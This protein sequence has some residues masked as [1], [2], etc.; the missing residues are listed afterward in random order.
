MAC[1]SGFVQLRA[2]CNPIIVT[3][4]GCNDELSLILGEVYVDAN[5]VCW[6]AEAYDGFCDTTSYVVPFPLTLYA[7]SP[8]N[9]T[10][11]LVDNPATCPQISVNNTYDLC[12][13]WQNTGTNILYRVNTVN[14]TPINNLFLTRIFGDGYTTTGCTGGVTATS[15]WTGNLNVSLGPTSQLATTSSGWDF[16]E[17]SATLYNIDFSGDTYGQTF[18]NVS[19]GSQFI[20]CGLSSKELVNVY[21]AQCAASNDTPCPDP[22]PTPTQTLTSTLTPTVTETSTNTPTPTPTLTET[23][24]NTPTTTPTVTETSTNTPTPTPTL[25][26]TPTSTPTPTPTLTETPTSTPTLTPTPTTTSAAITVVQFQ[27]CETGTNIFRFGGNISPLTL[28]SVY[29]ITGSSDFLGC[30]TVVTDNNGGPLY[31][32]NGVTFTSTLGCAD[33]MCPATPKVGAVLNKCSDGTI[34][35]ALVDENVSFVGATYVYNGFC[36]SFIERGG[37]G[38]PDLGAPQ[39]SSCA[40]CVPSLTLTPTPTMPT[41]T[42]TPTEVACFC[43]DTVFCLDTTWSGLDGYTGTYTQSNGWYNCCHFYEGGTYNFGVIYYTGQFWCLSSSLGGPCLL[44]G[45]KTC[46]TGCP[47]FDSN[48][49]TVG[50]CPPPPIPPADCSVLDFYAYFDCNYTPPPT[51]VPCDIVDFTISAMTLTPTPTPTTQPCLNLGINF[52]MSSYT[53]S[54]NVTPTPTP[55]LTATNPIIISGNA[56]FEV[57]Q[58]QFSCVSVKVLIDCSTGDEYY[59]SDTLIYNGTTPIT[60]GMTIYANINGMFRCV[61][62]DRDDNNISSNS[63]ISIIYN[64]WGGGCAQCLLTPTPTPTVTLT[65]TPTLTASVTV[66]QTPTVTSSASPT[67][68]QTPTQTIRLTSTPTLTPTLTLTIG[69]TPTVTPT[70][71]TTPTMSSTNTP[72]QTMTPSQTTTPTVTATPTLTTTPTSTPYYVYVYQSCVPQQFIPYLENQVIQTTQVSGVVQIGATF[73]DSTGNCW[74][75]IGRFE[76]NYIP[77]INVVATTYQGDYFVGRQSTLYDSCDTCIN[78]LPPTGEFIKITEG[79]T[80][81]GIPDGCGGYAGNQIS[82]TLEV[83]NSNGELILASSNITVTIT[84]NYSD[85][86]SSGS[87][88]NTINVTI[89]A[90]QNSKSF[91]FL[92]VD[93]QPCPFDLVCSP[94]YQ[95]Y[96]SILQIY[97]STVL[98]F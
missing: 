17:V 9:C 34:F 67:N 43:P 39:F 61:T 32:S 33:P 94:V 63:I 7:G 11:C 98:Q 87:Q 38:G 62:Y 42:P 14:G 45:S 88:T 2:C 25:T 64:I 40:S 53:P 85:C 10:Q 21:V 60:Q 47:D 57:F 54:T 70:I 52:S 73:K 30:A 69:L 27:D 1:I 41:P 44:S 59:V 79:G 89:P 81:S 26:E 74:R 6:T 24:T 49:F 93:Y 37:P 4:V 15:Q 97:P 51:S 68:T 84:L 75:Y 50:A 48:V 18:L 13:Y 90:G 5:G 36:Y 31:S 3:V 78:G 86:L 29:Y 46:S 71:T 82:Y 83:V 19:N 35:Y 77:P 58:E 12:I 76:S 8:D 22:T 55:S 91:N 72:T 20:V 66:T 96:N 65:Q 16:S 23:P 80:L 95:S 56:T 92:S 28:G